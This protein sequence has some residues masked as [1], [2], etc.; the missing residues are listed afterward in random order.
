MWK[1]M[2]LINFI[3]KS[4]NLEAIIG[5][6]I[7]SKICKDYNIKIVADSKLNES[8]TFKLIF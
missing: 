7:V 3:I 6:N 1:T 4:F 5:L 8:T 2:Y